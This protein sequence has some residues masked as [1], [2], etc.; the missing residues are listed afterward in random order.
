M[1]GLVVCLATVVV[2]IDAGWQPLDGGGVE[3]LIQIEPQ[4]L[5]ALRSGETAGFLQ[6]TCGNVMILGENDRAVDG[7]PPPRE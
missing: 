6:I 2:G 5:D 3:Y 7:F 1:C 4:L